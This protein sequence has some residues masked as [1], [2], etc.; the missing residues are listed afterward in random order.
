MP[1]VCLLVIGFV[2]GIMAGSS[3][4]S[5]LRFVQTLLGYGQS[6]P[7]AHAI[8]LKLRL[9]RTLLAAL[10][11]G[12]LSL[13]GLVFQAVLRNP[14]ADPYILGVSGGA[15]LGGISGMLLGLPVFWGAGPLAFTGALAAFGASVAL[16]RKQGSISSSS[17]ILSGVMVN[18][19]CSAIILF[20]IAIAQDH[21]LRT[22][23]LWL[24]GDTSAADLDSA[25]SLGFWVLPVAVIPILLS[26]KMNLL[27][28][29]REAA[30]NLG[31]RIRLVTGL[32][33]FSSVVM[34]SAV[35]SQTG[36]LG[37]VGLVCPHIMRL[38]VGY[39]HRVL[40]PGAVLFGATFLVFCD[41]GA[42]LLSQQGV[43]PVGVL[44][45]L[46]GAPAFFYLLRRSGP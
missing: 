21:T 38:I 19:F 17:L 16:S 42:R 20:F 11:G 25:Y 36:L 15:A 41:V 39:D 14:L 34:T 33:L 18:T 23:L 1:L 40:V 10:A 9:P 45:S 24:M 46:V 26:H 8:L 27:L 30:R 44:T 31:V 2:A 12:A 5:P 35:V 28:L 32:L 29:G 4:I 7:I 37:F 22:T 13:S 3:D 43:M 6:D